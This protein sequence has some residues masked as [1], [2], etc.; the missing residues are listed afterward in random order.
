LKRCKHIFDVA[1]VVFVVIAVAD[2]ID[3]LPVINLLP[4]PLKNRYR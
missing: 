1:V 4:Y 3:C 2:S